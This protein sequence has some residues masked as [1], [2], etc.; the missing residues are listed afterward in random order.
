[1]RAVAQVQ[2]P[3]DVDPGTAGVQSSRYIP[4]SGS[5]TVDVV[6][7][8]V[9][10]LGAFNFEVVYGQGFLSAPTIATG[11]DVDRNPNANQAYLNSTGRTFTCSPP[12][13][14]GDIDASA[15]VGA[16]FLS[17]Y[18]VGAAAGPAAAHG[19]PEVIA[20]LT[21]NV[22][23]PSGGSALTLRNLNMYDITGTVELA[24]CAPLVTTPAMC[25]S[26]AVSNRTGDTDGDGCSDLEEYG[27]VAN[28]GGIRD[29]DDFWDYFDT[30]NAS[31]VR[32]K[33]ATL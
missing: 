29:P 31:N 16:A 32:D 26:A 21:F 8:D 9:E 13:P 6:A 14:S 2:P 30:P 12:S 23:S 18:S 24:S 28:L 33:V 7:E 4:T 3:V 17:C 10:A 19:A 20:T 1:M 22:L 27:S 15:S 11:P 5:F 25:R